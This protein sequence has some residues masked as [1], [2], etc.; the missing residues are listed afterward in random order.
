M[1]MILSLA[2]TG[3]LFLAGSQS[4]AQIIPQNRCDS[5]NETLNQKFRYLGTWDDQGRPDY[6]ENI[7]DTIPESLLEY[8]ENTLPE[9]ISIIEANTGL[10]NPNA[11][12]NTVLND[13]A[14]VYITYIV[15]GAGRDFNNTL[16]Y[17]T[18]PK[19]DPPASVYD[20]DSLVVVFPNIN[21]DGVLNRGDK[22]K[23]GRFPPN[24][25]I[26]YFI[27]PDGWVEDTICLNRYMVFSDR[28]LN[29]H[30]TDEY[31]QH[32]ILLQDGVEQKIVL[33]F[34]DLPRPSSDDDFNDVVFW[35]DA[36]PFVIDTT[37]ISTIPTAKIEGDTVLCSPDDLAQVR[38]ALTGG[39]P[40][41]IVYFDGS[42]EIEVQGIS[43]SP[44][45]FETAVKDTIV[46]RSVKNPE[47]F[48]TVS[49]NAIIRLALTT[50]TMAE[51]GYICEGEE[52]GKI[53]ID[54]TGIG[55][56][57]ISY[58]DGQD[59]IDVADI[60]DNPFYIDAVP[61]PEYT[62]MEVSD[63]YCVGE[64][65]GAARVES[66][67]PPVAKLVSSEPVCDEINI[68][69]LN[70]ELTDPG[71]HTIV[72]EKDGLSET[73]VVEEGMSSVLV[74]EP[75]TYNLVYVEDPYCVGEGSGSADVTMPQYPTVAVNGSSVVCAGNT[76]RF[77]L[78]LT[79]Q[80]PW[81]VVYSFAEEEFTV[82][83]EGPTFMLEATNPGI[84]TLMSVEDA[85]C[86]GS[87]Q[88]SA[89][90]EV[91]E[92]PSAVLSGD[93]IICENGT[94]TLDV[95]L[96]GSAP[97]NLV[98]T[99]GSTDYT[100][101]ATTGGYDLT[102]QNAGTY[103]LL[104]VSDAFCT[105]LA[106][107]SATLEEKP[108]PTAVISGGGTICAGE[109][110]A[111]V[112]FELTGN[113]PWNVTYTDG[114]TENAITIEESPY[115]LIAQT[116]GNYEIVSLSD[117]Y[118]PGTGSGAAEVIDALEALEADI[119]TD[120]LVCFGEP[121]D[122]T[123][124]GVAE[125]N[126][127][128]FTSDGAG[129]LSQLSTFEYTYA[130]AEGESGII[131]FSLELTNACGSK[132]ITREV[133]IE[134]ELDPSFDTTPGE[135]YTNTPIDFTPANTSYD[136]YTWDFGDGNTSVQNTPQHEYGEAG[137]YTVILTVEKNGCEAEGSAEVAIL[138][139]KLLFVPSA[140]NPT[141][142]NAENRVVKV[143]GTGV[144]RQEFYFRIVNRWGKTM[145]E[146]SSWDEANQGGWDG[147]N[148]NVDEYQELNVFTYILRGKF[149]DNEPFEQTG[150]VTLVK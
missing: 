49:G 16:G 109:E 44:Y 52:V 24:T 133:I 116:A 127:T 31:R 130:P 22:V 80:S 139:L 117:L 10:F 56:W 115:T 74:S 42:E 75:G 94:A 150:T 102:V 97:W 46:L 101:T 47:G 99:D 131:T 87:V 135:L 29:I 20:L 69:R 5:I 132:T 8:I 3:L 70:L 146:T 128:S 105:G 11:Q 110:T 104:E 144:S 17:Y 64:A 134:E 125:E 137:M 14:D 83:T 148:T 119:I 93:G 98:Y 96:T 61:G 59:I 140:F 58:S 15:E 48:G 27:I 26:G 9:S 38:I 2:L 13:T 129:I 86:T 54:L 71:P 112:V 30:T 37:D 50:A 28:Q 55:P 143:Y 138:E 89:V 19:G 100:A 45:I 63:L 92:R 108:A 126:I 122:I 84:Y 79:G 142:L 73:F 82:T 35:V 62:L 68:A 141:A 107:G 114:I 76:A 60:S 23:I 6:L 32:T 51:Q 4:D 90:L 81:T 53:R 43:T 36:D 85:F 1:K 145:Y 25:V 124:D 123:I 120:D 7:R 34:E 67:A 88:G 57:T 39:G 121:I 77:E 118:C 113:A 136:T 95:Q 41:D 78:A 66:K 12:L 18:Y 40:W 21:E 147:L 33:G 106:E 149:Q 103:T 65:S 91:K 111:E 72:L